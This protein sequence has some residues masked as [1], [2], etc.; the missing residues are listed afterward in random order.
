M[1]AET[2]GSIVGDYQ[3]REF[4]SNGDVVKMAHELREPKPRELSETAEAIRRH[5]NQQPERTGP[6]TVKMKALQN[7]GICSERAAAHALHELVAYGFICKLQF[8]NDGVRCEM[9]G[10]DAS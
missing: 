5:L 1:T 2:E 9:P 7:V 8:V 10:K 4:R 6:V 3:S